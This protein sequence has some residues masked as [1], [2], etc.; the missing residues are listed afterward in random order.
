MG[1][2]FDKKY[3]VATMKH[4]PSQMIWGVMSCRGTAGLYFIPPNTTMNGPKDV[5]LFKEKL[6]LHIHVHLQND[7]PRLRSN[8]VTEFL[9]K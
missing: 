8:A 2:V 7:A 5:E 3:V 9:K 1:M 4:P 6:K